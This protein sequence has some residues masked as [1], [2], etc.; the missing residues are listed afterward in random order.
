MNRVDAASSHLMRRT[1]IK[2]NGIRGIYLIHLALAVHNFAHLDG[3][4][5]SLP[6]ASPIAV[7]TADAEYQSYQH[8]ADFAWGLNIGHAL[9]TTYNSII[10][11]CQNEIKK[12]NQNS[13]L[14]W[15]ST[16]VLMAAVGVAR[17]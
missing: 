15:F 14:H 12:C 9:N 4:Y 7:D 3:R 11:L 8:K 17:I 2:R 16:T 6:I 10:Q 5:T 1:E 13:L